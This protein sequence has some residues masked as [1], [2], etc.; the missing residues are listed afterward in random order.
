MLTNNDEFRRNDD[1]AEL[2]Q[3]VTTVNQDMESSTTPLQQQPQKKGQSAPLLFSLF[4]LKNYVKNNVSPPHPN[5]FLHFFFEILFVTFFWKKI[6]FLNF[7]LFQ[8]KKYY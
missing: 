4:N 3:V 1:L 7:C 6:F 5:F 8:Y 2:R